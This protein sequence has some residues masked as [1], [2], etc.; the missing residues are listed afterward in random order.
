MKKILFACSAIIIFCVFGC[1]QDTVPVPEFDCEVERT[2]Q[3]DVALIIETNCAYSG[4]HIQGTPGVSDYS[5]YN[6]L[7][8][9][10]ESGVFR[11]RVLD[12]KTMPPANAPGPDELSGEELEILNCWIEQGYPE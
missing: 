9:A 1:Q 11:N 6:K 4:C 8:G 2:Y 7:A 12:T 3:N 10:I 5:D